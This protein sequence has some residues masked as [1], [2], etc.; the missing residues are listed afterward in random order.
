MVTRI[1]GFPPDIEIVPDTKRE[2]IE[3]RDKVLAFRE[4]CHRMCEHEGPQ[5]DGIMA[6]AANS[7]AFWLCV[8]GVVLN[9]K[10]GTDLIINEDDEIEEIKVPRGW[11][12]FIMYP[13]QV[14]TINWH[15]RIMDIDDDETGKADGVCEKSRDMG[16]TWI[17]V[18]IAAHQWI[19]ADDYLCMFLSYK[20]EMVDGP[21]P[22]AMFYKLR[23]LLG[24]N[25]RVPTICHA[26]HTPY[27]G[28]KLRLPKWMIP[29]GFESKVHDRKLSI[30]HPT[31]T[32]IITGESTTGKAGTGDRQNEVMLDEGSKNKEIG[33]IWPG[34]TAVTDHRFAFSS[35]SREDGDGMFNLVERARAATRNPSL[36]G[37]SFLSLPWHL[38]PLRDEGWHRRMRGRHADNPAKFRREYEMDWNAG[39]GDWVYPSASQIVPGHYPYSPLG[40]DVWVSIDPGIRDPTCVGAFQYIPATQNQWA[41]FDALVLTTDS[42]RYLAPILM[43]WP[44]GH[45]MRSYYP[46]YRDE[47]L[48]QF[49]DVM[50]EIRKSGKQRHYV[51]DTYGNNAGGAS[52]ES[53]YTEM[54]MESVD[55]NSKYTE[56]DGE[57]LPPARIAVMTK[58][59]EKARFHTV[60]KEAATQA[61]T[62]VKFND[63]HRVL[64]VLDALKQ[65]RYRSQN[66]TQSVQ[67]EPNA[68]L[69]D[70]TSHPATMF[71]YFAVVNKISIGAQTPLHKPTQARSGAYAAVRR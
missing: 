25:T 66:D 50:W 70:W 45:P 16:L 63:I 38:H 49:M 6:L 21:S 30:S 52:S 43:G 5:R 57:P 19:F 17:F 54:L 27:H 34:L 24:L 8:F 7:K 14:D 61:L 58:Y 32:N 3:W 53:F 10:G 18:G 69:H 13:F 15:D 44:Q 51:G 9:P 46:E 20:E 29:S 12:P 11:Y 60:R 56:W 47:S 48:Q 33:N 23:A 26:P 42:A 37:P 2:Y 28:A 71:E 67:N 22:K 62:R 1:P 31:K 39:I 4:L 64:Y 68:P 59:D 65:N 40:G 36:D 35:A 55:L 41:L